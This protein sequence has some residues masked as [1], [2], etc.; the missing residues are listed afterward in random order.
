MTSK[1]K[2]IIKA[3]T[4]TAEITGRSISAEAVALIA[5][6]LE[7]HQHEEVMEALHRC[8]RECRNG[9]LSLADIFDRLANQ[10]LG[11]DAAWEKAVAARIW[12]EE[13]TLV[14]R[15]AILYSF[16]LN[17]WNEGDKVAARMAF[18]HAYPAVLAQY[19]DEVFVSLGWDP[20]GRISAIEEAVRNGVITQA[21][22]KTLLAG[23]MT[24]Q[25]KLAE[26]KPESIAEQA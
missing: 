23:R 14:I 8:A 5:A 1:S 22:V 9:R 3:I 2:E 10:P 17:L 25:K 15:K 18:K 7:A 21:R 13:Q 12:D 24:E 20:E 6:E 4:V 19:G 11:A 16:P 26:S